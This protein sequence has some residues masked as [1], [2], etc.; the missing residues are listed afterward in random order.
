[1]RCKDEKRYRYVEYLD[2]NML[3][4]KCTQAAPEISTYSCV[5]SWST[6]EISFKYLFE[7]VRSCTSMDLKM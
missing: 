1:M 2:W 3:I 6:T 5:A 4:N 7:V